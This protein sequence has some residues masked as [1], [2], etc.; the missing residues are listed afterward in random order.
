MRCVV[1]CAVVSLCAGDIRADLVDVPEELADE[2]EALAS[3]YEQQFSVE[4]SDQYWIIR[5]DLPDVS[6][7]L[8]GTLSVEFHFNFHVP[9]PACIPTITIFNASIPAFARFELVRSWR[10]FV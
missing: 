8:S 6:A 9:Y 3:I 4:K 7:L 1:E 10:V 5:V 2:C